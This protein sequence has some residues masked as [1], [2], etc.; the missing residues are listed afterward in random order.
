[1]EEAAG[2][3]TGRYRRSIL[4][5]T[6]VA[7][8]LFLAF[9][10]PL[11]LS[12]A[13]KGRGASD[14]INYHKKAIRAFS[15]QFPSLD[16]SDYLSATTPG[17]HVLVALFGRVVSPDRTALQLFSSLL[18]AGLIATLA[19]ACAWRM[20]RALS[21]FGVIAV[22][23]PFMTSLYVLS[24][25]V[26]LLP[27]NTAWWLLLCV[28]LLSLRRSQ[29]AG[30]WFASGLLLVAL[31]FARQ[32]HIWA[33]AIIWLAAWI[34][35]GPARSDAPLLMRQDVGGLVLPRIARACIALLLTL[36]AFALLYWFYKL[37]GGL[38]PPTFKPMHGFS[39]QA[40]APAFDL[41]LLAIAGVFYISY[42]WEPF[43]KL[44]REQIWAVVL[45]AAI[46]LVLATLPATTES[47]SHGRVSGIFHAVKIAP[48]LF[49]HTSLLIA[50]LSTLGAVILVA[51]LRA[52][53][54]RARWIMLAAIAGFSAANAAN[55]QLWQRYHEPFI[56]MWTILAASLA[57]W[58]GG[59][60]VKRPGLFA[61]VGPLALAALLAA[62]SVRGIFYER[63]AQDAGFSPGHVEPSALNPAIP[64]P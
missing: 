33:A 23:L 11:I 28:L 15:S 5:A 22:C 29:H 6:V 21:P 60:A 17:Y 14:S 3:S 55:P 59:S 1:M 54:P 2:F 58:S 27:D 48:V 52:M 51:W 34:G 42:W 30:V 61:T 50:P 47:P 57:V 31:V 49:A 37:W 35:P 44:L 45:A 8:L 24:S 10:W 25:G 53:N 46:G 16:F 20:R 12:G 63:T 56:L 36:P 7:P 32:I 39:P 62:V 43:L 13:N 64:E 9:S 19:S 26:W 4:A 38:T 40:A 41:A 18:S